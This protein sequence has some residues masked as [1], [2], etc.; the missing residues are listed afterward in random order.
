MW[1]AV[2]AFGVAI[3][4][5]HSGP[6]SNTRSPGRDGALTGLG[7]FLVFTAGVMFAVAYDIFGRLS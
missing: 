3:V 2:G 1:A 5:M 4:F 7:L 6:P